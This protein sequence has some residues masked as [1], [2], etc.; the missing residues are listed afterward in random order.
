MGFLDRL[1][2]RAKEPEGTPVYVLDRPKIDKPTYREAP[3]SPPV[4]AKKPA[5]V[6]AAKPKKKE[7]FFVRANRAFD[8]I[9]SGIGKVE[10]AKNQ[11]FGLANRGMDIF[12]QGANI[13]SIPEYK[14]KG[15]K[16]RKKKDP[17]DLDIGF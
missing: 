16:S 10:R 5:K 14:R 3:A 9:E 7:D 8:N 1:R 12:E 15:K 17:F 2:E 11:S 13:F 4:V 6:K